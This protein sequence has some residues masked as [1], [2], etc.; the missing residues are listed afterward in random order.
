MRKQG[1]GIKLLGRRVVEC[2]L[3]RVCVRVCAEAF[4][5]APKRGLLHF[6]RFLFF[7]FSF[8]ERG[9][10]RQAPHVRQVKGV[11]VPESSTQWVRDGQRPSPEC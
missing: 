2:V 6:P 9:V 7:C 3:V 10:K 1:T 8:R 11:W 4:K 5:G